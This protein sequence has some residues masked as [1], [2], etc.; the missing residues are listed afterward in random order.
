MTGSSRGQ[1]GTGKAPKGMRLLDGIPVPIH[2]EV[3]GVTVEVQSVKLGSG[4]GAFHAGR[5]QL[6]LANGGSVQ[7]CIDC[8]TTHTH[9]SAILRHREHEHGAPHAAR[10]SRK[11]KAGEGQ[12]GQ[13]E[14]ASSPQQL[15][16]AVGDHLPDTADA[17]EHEH[18]DADAGTVLEGVVEHPTPGTVSTVKRRGGKQPATTGGFL[19]PAGFGTMPVAEL[20]E[21]IGQVAN[22][23]QS[24][25]A[26]RAKTGQWKNRALAAERR[27]RHLTNL[28][29]KAGFVLEDS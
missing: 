16:F 10:K 23:E 8:P 2:V 21:L 14:L 18:T 15:E 12:P 17:A 6:Y 28:L 4:E 1:S 7:G 27:L 22:W 9:W 11:Q 13:L 20:I 29:G 3:D 25:E 24:V 5:T 19:L 26:E